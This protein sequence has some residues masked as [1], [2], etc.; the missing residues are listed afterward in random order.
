MKIE[1]K[2]RHLNGPVYERQDG[3]RIHTSGRILRE[4]GGHITGPDYLAQHRWARIAGSFR[5]GM[6]LWANSK[7]PYRAMSE[8]REG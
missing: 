3:L 1:G 4:S 5:R 7:V 8:G 2:W 6:M